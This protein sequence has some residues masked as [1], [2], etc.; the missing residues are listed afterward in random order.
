MFFTTLSY[1]YA[2]ATRIGDLYSPFEKDT[3]VM[4]PVFREMT[5][6]SFLVV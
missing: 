6:L 3:G 2:H 1:A 5:T 4:P